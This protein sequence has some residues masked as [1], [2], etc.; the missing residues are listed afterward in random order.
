MSVSLSMIGFVDDSTG[1]VN[2]FCDNEQPTPEFL[3]SIMQI[4]AQLWSNLLWLSGGLLELGKCSFHQIHFDFEPDGAPIIRGGIYGTPLQVHDTLTGQ[5][6]TIPAKLVYTPHKT[7]GHQKAPAGNNLT[8]RQ[9]LQTNSDMYARLVATSP[10]NRTDSWFFYNAIYLK[11]LGYV[12]SGCFFEEKTLLTIQKAALQAFLAKCGYNRNTQRTIV[13]APIRYGGCGFLTLYLIQGEGQILCFL[14]HWRNNTDAGNLL[15]IAVAWTQLHIGTSA[16]F[17]TD[18]ETPLPHLPGWWLRSLRTFLNR[19]DGSLEL[20]S[21]FLPP[22]ERHRD[23]YIMDMV[24]ASDSFTK[25]EICRINYCR[26]FLQAVTL[27]DICLAD[28][29][30]LD[31]SMVL[32]RLDSSTST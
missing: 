27:S 32:G 24:L 12:L 16:C 28:G 10:F 22:P 25:Q 1:Q 2:A 19:I 8:Q 29:V 23:V 26:L 6:V 11:S 15:R 31:P 5:Q 9:V 3:R 14:K 17:L 7:L 20:D 21:Y 18:T 13:F 30:H 4:D